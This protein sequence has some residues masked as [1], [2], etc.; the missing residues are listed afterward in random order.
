MKL[1]YFFKSQCD[2]FMKGVGNEEIIANPKLK[3]R[4]SVENRLLNDK[5]AIEKATAREKLGI[6]TRNKPK[7]KSL[8]TVD[9]DDNDEETGGE[10]GN[11]RTGGSDDGLLGP[12]KASL[13]SPTPENCFALS[14]DEDYDAF[15]RSLLSY[16]TNTP[17]ASSRKSTADWDKSDDDET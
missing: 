15:R 2:A 4:Q 14:D 5:R 9:D 8:A 12:A 13:R 7:G 1:L 10:E 3:L 11:A 6:I 16:D 17:S